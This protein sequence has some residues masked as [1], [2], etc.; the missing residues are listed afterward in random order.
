MDE[1]ISLTLKRKAGQEVSS[2]KNL[3]VIYVKQSK[4]KALP[5]DG[6]F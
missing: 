5:D 1:M 3:S 4:V 6:S 2:I